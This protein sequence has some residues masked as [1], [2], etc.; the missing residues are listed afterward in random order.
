MN[1]A[2]AVDP[3]ARA[4]STLPSGFSALKMLIAS[5]PQYSSDCG[6]SSVISNHGALRADEDVFIGPD[7]RLV[8]E[9]AHCDVHEYPVA[10]DRVEKRAADPAS[11]VVL[12]VV[13]PNEER[14]GPFDDLELVALEPGER[15]G[16]LSSRCTT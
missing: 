2:V 6:S 15:L 16:V 4:T 7:R 3:T 13:T 8:D 1:M 10:H 5:M 14:L 11:S 12:L 9:R